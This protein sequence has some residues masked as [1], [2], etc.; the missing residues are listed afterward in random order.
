MADRDEDDDCALCGDIV[1]WSPAPFYHRFGRFANKKGEGAT[2]TVYEAIDM[3][4]GKLVAW[5]EVDTSRLSAEER[6][7]VHAE[8]AL[9][10]QVRHPH[11]IEYHASWNTPGAVVFI[12]AISESGDLQ[13]FYRTHAVKLKVLKKWCRQILSGLLYLHTGFAPPIIHRDIKCENILYSAADGTL[14]I[15]DLG[16]S[17]RVLGDGGCGAGGGGAG[18]GGAAALG[19][20]NYMAPEMYE[21]RYS[22]TVDVY[23]FGMCVR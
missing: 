5:N 18:E 19:T 6:E 7:R 2:K 17:T 11:I 21:G 15:G 1:E 3:N 23:S 12:T 16:L 10:Q 4:A 14:R 20:P 13:R 9:L 8:V 22:E